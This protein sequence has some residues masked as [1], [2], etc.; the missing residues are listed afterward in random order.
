MAPLSLTLADVPE[1]DN[2]GGAGHGFLPAE[3]GDRFPVRP[4]SP[5]KWDLSVPDLICKPLFA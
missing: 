3:A 2:G 5:G 4:V 1:P